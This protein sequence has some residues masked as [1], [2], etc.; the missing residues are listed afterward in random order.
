[1]ATVEEKARFAACKAKEVRD[2]IRPS[3][4]SSPSLNSAFG[5]RGELRRAAAWACVC[6]L[7]LVRGGA[8]T[9]SDAAAPLLRLDAQEGGGGRI[10]AACASL[11]LCIALRRR[12]R[13]LM[14]ARECD[15]SA[16]CTVGSDEAVGAHA[17]GVA[18]ALALV[19]HVSEATRAQR[20]AAAI[21]REGRAKIQ[22]MVSPCGFSLL[23][24]ARH[25]DRPTPVPLDRAF[26]GVSFGGAG[27]AALPPLGVGA[28][29]SWV[30][31]RIPEL[32]RAKLVRAGLAMDDD[33]ECD[34]AEV[35]R[36][37]LVVMECWRD[38]LREQLVSE[39]AARAL[40]HPDFADP[41]CEPS[42]PWGVLGFPET[43][44][45][46]SPLPSA[47]LPAPVAAAPAPP[48][49]PPLPVA[50]PA[51]PAPPPPPVAAPA[52]PAPPPVS[53]PA[54]PIPSPR[55]R[56]CQT[57]ATGRGA[58]KRRKHAASKGAKLR[59]RRLMLMRMI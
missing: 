51:P 18:N 50:A 29:G 37:T 34:A 31:L 54:S 33:D 17:E 30:D 7:E 44:S 35:R 41:L 19:L 57:G 52:P 27:S 11:C 48:A 59:R 46:P 22:R 56:R 14:E 4:W 1:M 15:F 20:G 10:A 8:C 55:T 32:I 21:R 13:Q 38:A 40:S 39:E 26:L 2:L 16:L 53:A 45:F 9:V 23:R 25:L 47:P 36:K 43:I 42:P 58:R 12:V 24:E 49:P 6:A 5:C 3:R 28:R